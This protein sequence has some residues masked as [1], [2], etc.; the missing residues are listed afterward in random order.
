[1]EAHLHMWLGLLVRWAHF[2]VGIAWIGA[3]V[4]SAMPA[5]ML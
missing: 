3:T 2:I 5:S 4:N 1:M